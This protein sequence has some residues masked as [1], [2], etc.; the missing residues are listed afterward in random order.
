[1]KYTVHHMRNDGEYCETE[2]TVESAEHVTREMLDIAILKLFGRGWIL[3]YDWIRIEVEDEKA[4]YVNWLN[5][6]R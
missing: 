5:N 4:E 1:M 2:D 6:A 3:D